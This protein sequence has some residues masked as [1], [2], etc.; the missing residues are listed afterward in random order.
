LSFV[1]YPLKK[2][3]NEEIVDVLVSDRVRVFE[4]EA[5]S[6]T[7]DDKGSDVGAGES[8][9]GLSRNAAAV[10]RAVEAAATTERHITLASDN[11]HWASEV[12]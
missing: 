6:G 7:R 3:C 9:L 2:L 4:V 5:M 8:L 1:I 12:V 11:V 10:G